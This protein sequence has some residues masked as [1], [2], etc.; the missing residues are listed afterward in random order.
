MTTIPATLHE[1]LPQRAPAPVRAS[2][3]AGPAMSIGDVIRIIKQRIF[4]IV[5]VW[6]FFIGMTVLGTYLQVRY[7]PVWKAFALIRVE[8][9]EPLS[10]GKE[11]NERFIP[12][13][14]MRRMLLDEAS[15]IMGIGVLEQALLDIEVQGTRWYSNAEESLRVQTLK[16]ELRAIPVE[17][18]SL[19]KVEMPCHAKTDPHRIV[20][21]VVRSYLGIKEEQSRNEYRNRVQDYQDEEKLL[22]DELKAKL[23]EIATWRNAIR[24]P[25]A[26]SGVN[27]VGQQLNAMSAFL[28][29][30]EAQKLEL[31]ALYETYVDAERIAVSPQM[32]Q[33]VE[34]DPSVANAAFQ[35]Q[36]LEEELAV[37][38]E[39]FGPNHRTVRQLEQRVSVVGMELEK[40]RDKRLEE[41][42][43]FQLEQARIAYLNMVDQ[44]LS[45]RENYEEMLA[46][47]RDLDSQLAHY[48]KLQTEA[49]LIQEK[50][51]QVRG[52]VENLKFLLRQRSTV[53]ITPAQMATPPVQ[54]SSPSW[55]INLPVGTFLGLIVSMSMALLLDLMDTKIRAPSDIL[56]YLQLPI[57]GTIPDADDEEVAIDKIETAVLD[58]PRSMFAEAFR[59]VRTNL[60]FAT[61]A[62]RQRALV[63]TAPKPEDG[64]TTVLV[65]L[66]ASI[67]FSGRRV[68]LVDANFRRP[69]LHSVFGGPN[70]AGLSNIL[71]GQADWREQVRR[72][73]L[74]NLDY[75]A[76][77]PSPPHPSELLGSDYLRDF[78]AS[79]IEDYDQVLFDTPPV[80]L[81]NDGLVL[82]SM[83]DGVVL[84]CR[85]RAYSR[86]VGSRAAQLLGR[87]NA[88]VLGAILNAAQARRGGYFREMLRSYYDYQPDALDADK[89]PQALPESKEDTS[90]N[91]DGGGKDDAPQGELKSDVSDREGS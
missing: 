22:Y 82:A 84:V 10:I 24:Q 65:N 71:I 25:G 50:Y 45:L 36:A 70:G 78:L 73:S 46:E 38:R 1:K 6:F 79:A 68:L 52:F 32:I 34:T 7:L 9:G 85:A 48:E 86:G 44:E 72:T 15:A 66:G 54:R 60:F 63:L 58:S 37:A 3:P 13:D 69:A 29:N 35:L 11:T 16:D 57:L 49:E 26:V 21:A 19:L 89:S 5:F 47:Q 87:V 83:V 17:G 88:H 27:V 28:A 8:P 51:N 2:A 41:I 90:G 67:V 75:I 14:T 39:K 56:R 77:G 20:N 23:D 81:V 40:R 55:A 91:A 33:M 62:E 64:K 61:A 80:L 31:K 18:T 30:L 4:L 76:A 59:T 42:K 53:R 43:N 12:A 74:E